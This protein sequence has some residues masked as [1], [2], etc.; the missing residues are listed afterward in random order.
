M[1]ALPTEPQ[2]LSILSL[3]LVHVLQVP[4]GR[5]L[6]LELDVAVRTRVWPQSLVDS[7][8]MPSQPVRGV[9]IFTASI[10]LV[11]TL[12]IIF[13]IIIVVV[14]SIQIVRAWRSP[15]TTNNVNLL[16][17]LDGVIGT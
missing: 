6:I 16:V 17:I 15:E 7:E 13:V 3:F 12:D 9:K 11:P 5:S 4:R 14:V 8:D 10:A 2:P 1:T